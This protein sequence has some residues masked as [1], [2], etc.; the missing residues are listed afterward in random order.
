MVQILLK[1]HKLE[2]LTDFE[3]NF[4]SENHNLVYGFLRRYG[5]N[6]EN[7]YDVVIFGFLK[8]VQIYNR[9]EDLRSKYDFA[10]ISWQYMRSEIGNHMRTQGAKKR[11]P[12]ETVISLD[13]DYGEEENLHDRIGKND[14]E[15]EAVEAELL[16]EFL[17]SVSDRQRKI[18]EMRMCGYGSSEIYSKLGISQSAYYMEMRRIKAALEKMIGQGNP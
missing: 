8:A 18:A 4:A 7:Y 13:A 5:Y 14:P 3:R 9:R 17:D 6:L 16:S 11:K 12:G 10:F 15:L 1:G 2:P